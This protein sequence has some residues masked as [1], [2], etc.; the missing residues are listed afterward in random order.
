[1]G[2]NI[3]WFKTSKHRVFHYEPLYYNEKKEKMDERY[4]RNTYTPGV[5]IRGKIR[6]SSVENKKHPMSSF[7]RK[8]VVF[9]SLLIMFILAYYF[10]QYIVLLFSAL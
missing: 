4:N 9:I 8:I 3:S 1:M 7:T 5:N 2:L 10:S 6:N